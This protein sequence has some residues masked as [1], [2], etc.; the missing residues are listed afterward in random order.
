M[1]TIPTSYI[2]D[3]YELGMNNL[4]IFQQLCRLPPDRGC[5]N[6]LVNAWDALFTASV[7]W[8][9]KHWEV[10]SVTFFMPWLSL[11]KFL[12]RLTC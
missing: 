1:D 10:S 4:D 12:K 7:C 8:H 5:R 6:Q 3:C 11:F 2:K 9:K